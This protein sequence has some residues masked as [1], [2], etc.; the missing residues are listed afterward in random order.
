MFSGILNP[1]SLFRDKTLKPAS[2]DSWC[3]NETSRDLSSDTMMA[4][5]ISFYVF[6]F[7]HIIN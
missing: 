7:L 4:F 1:K 5:G 3:K 6:S 2:E